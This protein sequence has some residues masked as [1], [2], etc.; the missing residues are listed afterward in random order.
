MSTETPDADAAWE[1]YAYDP[2]TK[3]L[4]PAIVYREKVAFMAGRE[5]LSARLDA[6]QAEN[7]ELK[8]RLDALR[9]S[10]GSDF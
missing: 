8:R 9:F 5:S 7:Q 4:R 6:L 2:A 10:N 3:E 1:T